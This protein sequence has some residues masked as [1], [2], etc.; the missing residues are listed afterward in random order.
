MKQ[1]LLDIKKFSYVVVDNE[2]ICIDSNM[3]VYKNKVRIKNLPDTNKVTYVIDKGDIKDTRAN[4]Y[5]LLKHEDNTGVINRLEETQIFLKSNCGKHYV[6]VF[7]NTYDNRQ[8]FISDNILQYFS[9]DV[10]LY[11][12]GRRNT[13]FDDAGCNNGLVYVYEDKTLIGIILPEKHKFQLQDLLET[14]N[15][16]SNV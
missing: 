10:T 12:D 5:S 9:S 8:V 11:Q 3:L 1:K 15:K 4:L 14:V 7:I 13:A 2:L 6:K 16:K